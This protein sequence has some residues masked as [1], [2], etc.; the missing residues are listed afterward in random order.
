MIGLR[1]VEILHKLKKHLIS[2]NKLASYRQMQRYTRRVRSL[3]GW[4][5][6]LHGLVLTDD[7]G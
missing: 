6:S 4:T 3:G 5:L 1:D 7:T 2:G